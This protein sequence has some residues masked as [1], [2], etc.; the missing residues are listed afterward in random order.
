MT[1]AYK[2]SAAFL[3]FNNIIAS[4]EDKRDESCERK[5]T[6]MSWVTILSNKN[7]LSNV[8]EGLDESHN[9]NSFVKKVPDI[10]HSAHELLEQIC[11]IFFKQI[12]RLCLHEIEIYVDVTEFNLVIFLFKLKYLHSVYCIAQ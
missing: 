12:A 2:I 8:N 6:P 11:L 10:E 3:A 9:S 1:N 5:C 7:A 4:E